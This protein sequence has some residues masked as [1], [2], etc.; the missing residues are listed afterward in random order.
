M[1]AM[2]KLPKPEPVEFVQ[3]D[4]NVPASLNADG[5]ETLLNKYFFY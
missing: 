1:N 4:I 5:K 2:Y 3:Q